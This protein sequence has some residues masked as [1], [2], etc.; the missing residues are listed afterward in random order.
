MLNKKILYL[1]CNFIYISVF[2]LI[3][4]SFL[5]TFNTSAIQGFKIIFFVLIF[6]LLSG[7]LITKIIFNFSYTN[8]KI[9]RLNTNNFEKDNIKSNVKISII[10][11]F[12]LYFLSYLICY[13]YSDISFGNLPF[14]LGIINSCQYISKIYFLSL[15]LYAFEIVFLEYCSF[16]KSYKIPIILKLIKLIVLSVSTS[17]LLNYYSFNGFLYSKI[18][19]DLLFFIYYIYQLKQILLLCKK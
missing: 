1:L 19:T 9:K 4:I 2:L 11:L 12:T 17:L 13:F 15:P 18:L 5:N 14:N 6:L 7:S 8:K 16:I 3:S 10:I